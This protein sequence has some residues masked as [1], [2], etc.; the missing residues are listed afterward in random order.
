M[1]CFLRYISIQIREHHVPGKGGLPCNHRQKKKAINSDSSPHSIKEKKTFF[2][3]STRMVKTSLPLKKDY[4]RLPLVHPPPTISKG[5]VITSAEKEA[6]DAFYESDEVSGH[7]PG[8][9]DYKSVR[10]KET[11][12]RER[13]QNRLVLG[14]L[15]EL[16]VK[17]LE[18]D[19]HPKIGFSKFCTLRPPHCVLAGSAGTHCL[20]SPSAG[21]GL[22]KRVA[23]AVD[24]DIST[25]ERPDVGFR[26]HLGSFV[27][28]PYDS[29]LWI[30]VLE[31]YEENFNNFFVDF[32]HPNGINPSYQF[33]GKKTSAILRPKMSLD[34]CLPQICM[35]ALIFSTNLI[36]LE[37]VLGLGA[38]LVLRLGVGLV[39]GLGG[40]SWY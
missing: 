6:V 31:V 36:E 4:G 2:A 28:C 7:C 9:K 38:R 5:R 23:M 15:R 8:Q 27:A 11:G 19:A 20:T 12:V 13:K 37:L 18:D 1:F 35:A 26:Q 10:D 14:N 17:F 32:L 40:Q 21:K 16:Y 29:K 25:A 34:F 30:E 33:P 24:D 22:V 39:L 3:T